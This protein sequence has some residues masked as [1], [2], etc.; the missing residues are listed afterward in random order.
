MGPLTMRL[1]FRSGL[2]P[3]LAVVLA[4]TASAQVD[5]S[6]QAVQSPRIVSTAIDPMPVHPGDTVDATVLTTPDVVSVEA[7]VAHVTIAIARV[8]PGTF[9]Q[10]ARVPKIARFF[11]GTYDVTFVARRSDGRTVETHEDVV[12][13]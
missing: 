12:V 11:H 3:A 8:E 4:G 5:D 6:P 9:R 2:I 10:T 1:L 13:N 7:Y